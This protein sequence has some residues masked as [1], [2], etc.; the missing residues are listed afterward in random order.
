MSD[1]IF[2]QRDRLEI[3]A[4]N[5]LALAF[6]DS[7]PV[8]EGHCLVIPK[9]HV[10]TY[11]DAGPEEHSA[12]SILIGEVSRI[13]NRDLSPD[14]YNIGANVGEAAGQTVFHFHIHIIPRYRGDV[15]DPRGGVRKVIPNRSCPL[16]DSK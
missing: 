16:R 12:I 6:K 4:E 10:A 15:A 13:L 14:G 11:F 7:C 1:C 9:R 3:I 5:E 8:S 2:C